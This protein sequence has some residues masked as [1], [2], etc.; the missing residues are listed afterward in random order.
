MLQ[1]QVLVRNISNLTD[2]RYCA[3]MGVHILLF[4]P[5]R[6]LISWEE[7]K[8]ISQWLSGIEIGIEWKEEF[9]VSHLENIPVDYVFTENPDLKMEGKTIIPIEVGRYTFPD[10]TIFVERDWDKVSLQTFLDENPTCGVVLHG[11]LEERPGFRNFGLLM[12]LLELL[13]EE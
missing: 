12:D 10:N 11:G 2:A 6:S 4:S 5:D 9:E 8:E 1:R 13:E 7:I 3:G